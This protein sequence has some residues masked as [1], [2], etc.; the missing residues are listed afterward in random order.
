MSEN[1]FPEYITFPRTFE[2]YRWYKPILVFIIATIVYVIL[3]A[4]I[5]VIFGQAYGFDNIFTL[6]TQGYESLNSEVGSYIGYLSVAIFI[7]SLY[8]AS[9]IV[10][11][12]PFS[13]Y[14]SSRGGWNW[15]LFFKSL[16][17][18]LAVYIIYE[19]ITALIYGQKG[20]N[21]LTLTFFI[22]CMIIVPLQCI[23]EEYIM[24]GL[25]MQTFG[26]WFKIPVLAIVL[27]SIVFTSLHPYSILGVIGV[28]IQGICL[29]FLTWRSNGLEAS[30][31][32]HSVNNLISAYFVA[33]GFEVSSSVITP[34]DFA[35]TIFVSVISTLLLYY[36]GTKKGWFEE[37]TEKLW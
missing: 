22:I 8:I 2:K 19:I 15:K 36:I 9:L 35:S 4:L 34:Y 24:R 12:R 17:I 33:L 7:P 21:T 3:Q 5:F 13:S 31:A 20:P 28:F 30:S 27:Q 29:G 18:P 23:G 14:S 32:I 11:D 10:R 37:K 6:A 16:P 1:K 26:S 25:V